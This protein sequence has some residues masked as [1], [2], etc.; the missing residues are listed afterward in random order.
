MQF[1]ALNMQGERLKELQTQPSPFTDMPVK[2]ANTDTGK[3]S[4]H[5]FSGPTEVQ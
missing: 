1:T 5:I 4:T 3:Q 2:D